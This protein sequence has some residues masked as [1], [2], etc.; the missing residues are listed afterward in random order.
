MATQSLAIP[1]L[2]KSG[3]PIGL[4]LLSPSEIEIDQSTEFV[5]H[6]RLLP[7]WLCRSLWL[8]PGLLRLGRRPG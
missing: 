5:E 8:R 7:L 4:L 2:L 6:S 1:S 3:L